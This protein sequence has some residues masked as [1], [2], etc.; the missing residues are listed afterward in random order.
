MKSHIFII[1]LSVACAALAA[2][3][4]RAVVLPVAGPQRSFYDSEP[5]WNDSQR[6]IP[7]NY[8]EAQGK[9][10]FYQQCVWC[11][12]DATPSGPSNRSNVAPAPPLMNDGAILNS[13]SDVALQEIIALGGNAV[14]KSAMMP[15]YGKSLTQDEIRALIVYARAISVPPYR[16]ATPLGAKQTGK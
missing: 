15:P 10:I 7:L 14:G 1:G 4:K 3:G 12:A 2:C 5:D 11:H 6:I 13:E 9:R 8:Q 16:T